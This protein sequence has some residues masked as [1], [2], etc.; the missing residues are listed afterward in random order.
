V[1]SEQ[2]IFEEIFER[3]QIELQKDQGFNLDLLG[4]LVFYCLTF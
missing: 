4:K 3:N 2:N 1:E